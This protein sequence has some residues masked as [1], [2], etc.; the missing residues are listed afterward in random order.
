MEDQSAFDN[1]IDELVSQE[2]ISASRKAG[3][4][5]FK[6]FTNDEIEILRRRCKTDLFFLGNILEYTKLSPTLH[7]SLTHWIEETKGCN[8]RLALLPRGH[9]KSTVLTEM[10]S[11]QIALPNIAEVQTYPHCLGPSVKVLIAHE[12]RETAADFLYNIAS[13]FTRKPG[14][15]ALFPECIPNKREQ[16]VNKWEL[17]IPGREFNR[18]ATFNT[19]GAGGAAQGGHFN[20]IKLDDLIGVS[21][22]DS[23]T[24]MRTT[25]QWFD[26]IISLLTDP[27]DGFDLIGTRWA[28]NDI[29]SH[30]MEIYGIHLE[31]SILKCIS[32][33]DIAAYGNG[34][35]KVYAR[36][37]LENGLPIFPEIMTP[38]RIRILRKNPV[39]WAA[40]YVNNPQES[41]MTEFTWP[42]KF[43]NKIPNDEIV[44]FTG[45]TQAIKRN[46]QDLDICVFCDPSMGQDETA[47]ESGIVVTGIDFKSNIFIL[48]TIKKRLRPPQLIDE[49]FRLF[50]RWRPRVVAIEE[51]NFS[52]IYRYWIT[53]KATENGVNLPIKAYKPGSARSKE[54]RI[55]GLSHFFSAGQVYILEGMHE[56]RDEYEQFPI[57]KSQHLLDALAQ[58]PVFWTKGANQE[59]IDHFNRKMDDFNDERSEL[60]GY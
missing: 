38:E 50:F 32:K 46:K 21:A 4:E 3:E 45:Q 20:W 16:R 30:A 18:D 31:D 54:A 8:Y 33:K 12:V 48:E 7:G 41:G 49:L 51:V 59:D 60:T 44:V 23:P 36:G 39:I 2:S 1:E 40:Q 25:I 15:V 24:V 6:D 47:D 11:V 55:R 43:Y 17:D 35:L 14:M 42:L 57:G 37:V 29:Y 27:T 5:Q 19:I 34:L 53:E 13:A 28:Y 58:G 52:A 22:R 9:Y 56:F 26:N 10:D